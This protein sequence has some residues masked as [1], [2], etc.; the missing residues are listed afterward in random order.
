[1]KF[2]NW[3]KFPS[4]SSKYFSYFLI[5]SFS[6]FTTLNVEIF[7][8]GFLFY[9]PKEVEQNDLFILYTFSKYLIAAVVSYRDFNFSTPSQLNRFKSSI[10]FNILNRVLVSLF[11]MLLMLLIKLTTSDLLYLSFSPR[12]FLI[13]DMHLLISSSFSVEKPMYSFRTLLK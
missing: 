4:Q 11:G 10:P 6:A 13:N 3:T 12:Y 5:Q 2:L 8:I 9:L 1:M 7:H